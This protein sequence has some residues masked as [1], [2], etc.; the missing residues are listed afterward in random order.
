MII[1]WVE[2]YENNYEWKTFSIHLPKGYEVE[3]GIKW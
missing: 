3:R 2:S 1:D